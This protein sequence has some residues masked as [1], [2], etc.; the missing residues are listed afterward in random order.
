MLFVT[1][2]LHNSLLQENCRG[3]LLR[4]SWGEANTQWF[5]L[6]GTGSLFESQQVDRKTFPN[7]KARE[8]PVF[9]NKLDYC[10]EFWVVITELVLWVGGNPPLH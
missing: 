6:I 1:I 8:L 4:G 7:A 10:V 9:K 3:E 5:F 2:N